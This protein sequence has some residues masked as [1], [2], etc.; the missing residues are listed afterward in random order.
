MY[1]K[2]WPHFL[3]RPCPWY[4]AF[5]IALLQGWLLALAGY[6]V[7]LLDIRKTIKVASNW[8]REWGLAVN[9]VK[10]KWLSL[11]V[12]RVT[13][14]TVNLRQNIFVCLIFAVNWANKNILTLNFSQFT[15]CESDIM[16]VSCPQHQYPPLPRLLEQLPQLELSQSVAAHKPPTILQVMEQLPH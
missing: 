7:A 12:H 1:I 14:C 2:Y 5:P 6:D 4:I 13:F 8:H 16:C 9:R 10:S 11:C 15:V 3:P